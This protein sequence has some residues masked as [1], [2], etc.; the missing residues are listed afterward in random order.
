VQSP[1]FSAGNAGWRL[2]SNG[3]IEANDGNFRGDITGASGSFSGTITASAGTIGGYTITT[4]K[5]KD[6]AGTTGLSSTVSV[7]DDIRFWAG[8][9]TPASAPFKVTE[10]GEL[11]ASDIIATGT[12]NAQA[13]YLGNGVYIDTANGLV[14]ESEGFNVGTAGH[15]RGGQTAYN[16]GTGFFLGYSGAAYKFSIG[17]PTGD[18]L[19]WDGTNL[20]V[21]ASKIITNFTTG[22]VAVT[23]G[24]ALYIG[25]DGK[26]YPNDARAATTNAFIGFAFASA[27]ADSS[28][29]IQTF[30]L[31]TGLSSLTIASIYYLSDG[32][33]T[34]DQSQLTQDNSQVLAVSETN[35]QSFT[36]GVTG[37]LGKV[38]ITSG[39]SSGSATITVK[40]RAG[41]GTGG[42]LLASQSFGPYSGVASERI[43]TFGTNQPV[44][45]ASTVYSI[46]VTSDTINAYWQQKTTTNPYA[47]GRADTGANDDYIFNTYVASTNGTIGTSAGTNSKKIGIAISAT[48]LQILNS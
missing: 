1:N 32:T 21:S 35:Y 47:S 6:A 41:T 46:T 10:S 13:G 15:V 37:M 8:H 5:I 39:V 26:V 34:L 42:T 43:I 3:N 12:I 4:D 11:T 25:T 18:Y 44:L 7:G 24:Q 20:S 22:S 29:A 48:N 17:V 31:F 36:A 9:T 28:V 33:D 40:I 38:T 14:V 23:A 30:G 27:S 16:T 45:T 19:T 2:D